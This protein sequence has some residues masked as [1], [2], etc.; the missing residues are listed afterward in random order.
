MIKIIEQLS[1]KSNY[2]I[3]EYYLS[4]PIILLKNRLIIFMLIIKKLLGHDFNFSIKNVIS[5]V[6]IDIVMCAID[7]D[8]DVL[9]H[10]IDS[11]RKFIKHPIGN[12]FLICPHSDRIVKIAKEKKCI[13]LDENKM[14]PI[15]K[16]DINY[17]VNG[18]NRSG[19]LFQQLLKWSADKYVTSE[20]F[21][22]TE[23]DTAYCRPQVFIHNHR[24][25]LPVSNQLCHLPYFEAINRLTGKKIDPLINVTS[26]HSLFEKTKL[27]VLK[28]TIE[29]RCK[30][31][32]WQGIIN[33][34]DHK[35]GSSVSDYETYGQF[36]YS[37]YPNDFEKEFWC[38]H[39]FKRTKLKEIKK[40][41]K[42]SRNKYKNISFHS[43]DE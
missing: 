40:I 23:A 28:Q 12:I 19:W 29:K 18:Q 13:F 6:P 4:H 3:I 5:N 7:K 32:W 26:H 14:L 25:L 16:K 33:K 8:Y 30:T 42:Q 22:I 2:S 43:Y 35:Q 15:T 1:N 38:N 10:V 21:L 31:V 27:R 20:H 17:T 39:S 34:L 41:I 9:V 24:V 11:I 37:N 36:A